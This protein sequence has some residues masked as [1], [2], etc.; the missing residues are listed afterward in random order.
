MV[1][2]TQVFERIVREVRQEERNLGISKL[3]ELMTWTQILY[4]QGDCKSSE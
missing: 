2:D 1:I 3:A 4:T